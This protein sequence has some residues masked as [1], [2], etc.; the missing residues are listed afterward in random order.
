M[1]AASRLADG[2]LIV[3]RTSGF[4]IARSSR[5]P[6]VQVDPPGD[7]LFRFSYRVSLH[8]AEDFQ[9]GADLQFWQ[10][11]AQAIRGIIGRDQYIPALKYRA[12]APAK[13]KP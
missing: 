5:N 7:S 3:W 13:S 1:V 2:G 8:A 4:A 11:H 9:L 6:V 12:L 10:Q